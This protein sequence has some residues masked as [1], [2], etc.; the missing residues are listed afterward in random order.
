MGL[1]DIGIIK[2]RTIGLNKTGDKQ[3]VLLQVEVM[4]EDIRTI[5]LMSQP[6]EDFNPA[7]N[8]RVLII[9]VSDS[10]QLAIAG[11]DDLTPGLQPGEKEIYSTDNP[12]TIK[13]AKIKF[14][15]DG[16]L[17]LN[18]GT[19]FAVRFSALE[20]AF[21]Q[22]KSDYDLHTHLYSPGPSAPAPTA[23]PAAPSTADISGAKIDEVLVP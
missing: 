20:T 2:G 23:A 4:G 16:K 17:T 15:T 3:R 9:P 21:N 12:V 19:D 18:G 14:G 11:S 6:G 5:E 8:C 13:K 22:L 10:Y 1:I 7:N